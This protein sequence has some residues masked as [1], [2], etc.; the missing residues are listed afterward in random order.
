MRYFYGVHEMSVL[1]IN[2]KTTGRIYIN[3]GTD[4]MTLEVFPTRV[5]LNCLQSLITT[6]RTNERLR[7]VRH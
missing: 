5:L 3:F 1:M 2:S 7:W 6:W 4:V